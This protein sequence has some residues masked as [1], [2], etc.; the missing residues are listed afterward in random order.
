M[1]ELR[2][3]LNQVI[4][5][6]RRF[7]E[8]YYTSRE[9]NTKSDSKRLVVATITVQ[10]SLEQLLE[11]SRKS[12]IAKKV[13]QDRK[14]TLS[15]RKWSVGLPKRVKDFIEKKKKLNPDLLGKFYE[16][17]MAYLEGIGEELAAWI[18]DIQTLSEIPRVP[19]D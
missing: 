5:A 17:L 8:M 11:I 7:K 4:I 18:E 13:L 1:Q 12:K 19:R 10:R 14:A 6:K 3:F 16:A 9:S 15:L 2:D